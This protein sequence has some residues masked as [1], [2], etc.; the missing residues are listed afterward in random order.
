MRNVERGD[1]A[2]NAH[3]CR[4]AVIVYLESNQDIMTRRHGVGSRDEQTI[5]PAK[6]YFAA[7]G[8]RSLYYHIFH[9]CAP[10]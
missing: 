9:E 7:V 2:I 6:F 5:V 4:L 10:P 1:P 8:A 3:R